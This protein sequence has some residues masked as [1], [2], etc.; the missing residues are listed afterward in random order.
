MTV[1]KFSF[2]V[3]KIIPNNEVYKN[4]LFNDTTFRDETK[5]YYTGTYVENRH[6]HT[7]WND[8]SEF[9][10]SEGVNKDD[11]WSEDQMMEMDDL[12]LDLT[13]QDYKY[14]LEGEKLDI[15]QI[16][17][18]VD[19]STPYIVGKI[20]GEFEWHKSVPTISLKLAKKYKHMLKERG[21][22]TKLYIVQDDC[23]CCS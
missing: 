16:T 14:S 19:K 10:R 8:F 17:H 5:T 9:I 23:A 1:T 20:I 4:L 18:D 22:K 15:M 3:G 13:A 12:I 6:R 11:K 2:I 7:T 21:W